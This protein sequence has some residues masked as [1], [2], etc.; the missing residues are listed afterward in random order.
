M[1]VGVCGS[2]GSDGSVMSRSSKPRS[3]GRPRRRRLVAS[4]QLMSLWD[5]SGLATSPSVEL[6]YTRQ[7][8]TAPPHDDE[9]VDGVDSASASDTPADGY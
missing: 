6:L 5:T 1:W 8:Q 7:T 3:G 2:D 9:P 4:D